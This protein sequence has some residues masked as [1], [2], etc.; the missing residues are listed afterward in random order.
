MKHHPVQLLVDSFSSILLKHIDQFGKQVVAFGKMIDKQDLV[1][2]NTFF[3]KPN[4]NVSKDSKA[5][6][7][8]IN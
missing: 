3:A 2:N 8:S 6:R 1:V 7:A 4:L 5:L